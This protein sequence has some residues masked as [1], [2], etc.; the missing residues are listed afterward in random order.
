MADDYAKLCRKELTDDPEEVGDVDKD[1]AGEAEE[2]VAETPVDP[3]VAQGATLEE[4]MA[5]YAYIEEVLL[6]LSV[7]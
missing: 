6:F 3:E 2:Q 5:K 1:G 4:D 7:L